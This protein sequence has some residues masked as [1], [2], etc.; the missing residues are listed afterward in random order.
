MLLPTFGASETVFQIYVIVVVIGFLVSLVLA[1]I[2]VYG[3]I[4]GPY[5]R[6]VSASARCTTYGHV[7]TTGVYIIHEEVREAAC[8]IAVVFTAVELAGVDGG[9]G[10]VERVS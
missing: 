4:A 2:F 8:V 9:V 5:K 10:S 1:W 6:V 7:E 3:R